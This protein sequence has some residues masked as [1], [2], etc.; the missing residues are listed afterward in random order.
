[1]DRVLFVVIT[2]IV[3][4]FVT[5]W[6]HFNIKRSKSDWWTFICYSLIAV[7]L[8][9]I[10]LKSI[11]NDIIQNFLTKDNKETF[12][13]FQI[14]SYVTLVG[15]GGYRI[16]QKLVSDVFGGPEKER[17][18]TLEVAVKESVD[19]KLDLKEV[20]SVSDFLKWLSEKK[21][22]SDEEIHADFKKAFEEA[23]DNSLISFDTI[24]KKYKIT[25]LGQ[26]YINVN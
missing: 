17:L 26:I 1:M 6:F 15:V 22:A 9:P 7:I 14:I 10:I 24:S 23:R 13:Y 18:K 11:G 5:A 21:E 4:T 8:S 19:E 3:A 25:A 12:E 20:S 16:V 2:Y